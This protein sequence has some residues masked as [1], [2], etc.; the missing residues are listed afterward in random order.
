MISRVARSMFLLFGC[1][2]GLEAHSAEVDLISTQNRNVPRLSCT[3]STAIDSAVVLKRSLVSKR[4]SDGQLHAAYAE[5]LA[6][7]AQDAETALLRADILRRLK[8]PEAADWY[9]ALRKTCR[10]ADAH[11]G[12]GL[13]AG[14]R[15]AWR[16]ATA[17]FEKAVRRS[18][19]DARFRNDLGYALLRQGAYAAS[20]FELRVAIE[21]DP[22][23]RLAA[24]NLLLLAMVS[25]NGKEA[26][27]LMTRWQ[28][29]RIEFDSLL[30]SCGELVALQKGQ[31]SACPLRL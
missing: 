24:M 16:D 19:A 5:V 17:E 27:Y 4:V 26:S 21:L 14:D 10:E 25:D 15:N 31:A 2:V 29:S 6:L 9:M 11:H 28:P 30:Q 1:L 12:L 8:R 20:E 13:L 3:S 23:N 22:D 7:P 18:P